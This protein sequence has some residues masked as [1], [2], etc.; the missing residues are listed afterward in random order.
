MKKQPFFPG[1]Q[2]EDEAARYLEKKGYQI[3]KRNYRT[4]GVEVDLIARKGDLLCFVEVKTRKSL[5][6]GLPEEFVD[7]AKRKKIIRGARIFIAQKAYAHMWVRFDI[8]SLVHRG[9]KGEMT[10]KHIEDA[11][12]E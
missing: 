11:F 6:Y 7:L 2:G 1:P 9:P 12:E 3:V 8:L 5:K 4:S 10:I